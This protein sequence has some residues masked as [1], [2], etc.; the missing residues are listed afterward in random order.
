VEILFPR[1]FVLTGH[2]SSPDP[3]V[4]PKADEACWPRPGPWGASQAPRDD[5]CKFPAESRCVQKS[6]SFLGGRQTGWLKRVSVSTCVRL[7]DF[8]KPAGGQMMTASTW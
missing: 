3:P 7:Q 2:R 5:A 8:I 1:A 4:S 6:G